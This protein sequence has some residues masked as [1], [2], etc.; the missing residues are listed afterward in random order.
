MPDEEIAEQVGRSRDAVHMKA[1]RLR[2]RKVKFWSEQEDQFLR[3]TYYASSCDELARRLGR[4]V[5]AVKTRIITLKLAP[6]VPKWTHSEISFLREA[7]GVMDAET[8][9]A[10]LGR[11]SAAVSKK[12]REIGLVHG[13]FRSDRETR[14]PERPWCRVM[15]AA[16]R[17]RLDGNPRHSFDAA[18]Q[19]AAPSLASGQ[20]PVVGSDRIWSPGCF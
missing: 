10:E 13:R 2:L 17:G 7:H 19:Q 3:E 18:P 8:I 1:R 14:S 12:L 15:R 5:L 6:K 9:A 16:T 20:T 4:S 11:T